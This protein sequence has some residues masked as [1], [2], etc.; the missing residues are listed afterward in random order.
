M[1]IIENNKK[2]TL[3]ELNVNC[4]P[5]TVDNI[6]NYTSYT[7]SIINTSK[8]RLKIIC[9]VDCVWGTNK[10]YQIFYFKY[11][12]LHNEFGPA[13]ILKSSISDNVWTREYYLNGCYITFD[14]FKIFLKNKQKIE[15]RKLKLQKLAN[16]TK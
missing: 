9:S 6:R 5:E 10:D 3:I 2:Y 16:L 14:E 4:L 15:N 7:K 13:S 8:P 12:K 11:G 1:K